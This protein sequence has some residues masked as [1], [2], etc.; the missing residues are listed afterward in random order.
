[1]IIV[2]PVSSLSIKDI[3]LSS[4]DVRM[5]LKRLQNECAHTWNENRYGIVVH[6]LAY[7]ERRTG[8]FLANLLNI[9]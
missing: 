2:E 4:N 6:L 1:M 8:F 5:A 3:G 7:D 9:S